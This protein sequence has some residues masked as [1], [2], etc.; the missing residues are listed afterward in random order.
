MR[1]TEPDHALELTGCG[2]NAL[3]LC[4]RVHAELAHLDV[5][6]DK[7]VRGVFCQDGVHAGAGI[8][9]V[10]CQGFDGLCDQLMAFGER[11]MLF[12]LI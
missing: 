5:G 12:Q 4:T 9:D 10:C 3:L 8:G 11:V 1:L 6:L 2:S 7:R